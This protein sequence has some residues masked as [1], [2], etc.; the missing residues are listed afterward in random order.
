MLENISVKKK[1]NDSEC[2]RNHVW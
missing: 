2:V 1:R